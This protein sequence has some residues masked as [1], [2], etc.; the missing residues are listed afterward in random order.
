MH[1]SRLIGNLNP[2]SYEA[3]ESKY[4]CKCFV[5]FLFFNFRKAHDSICRILSLLTP[6]DS[7]ISCKVFILLSSIPNLHLITCLS[8]G[9]RLS[10]TFSRSFFMNC[11]S[12]ISSA[13]SAS[14]SAIIS[15]TKLTVSSENKTKSKCNNDHMLKME[16]KKN[17]KCH[18]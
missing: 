4:C 16:R 13:V 15:W 8:L 7:P 10:N 1:S 5:L 17:S 14:G 12:I 2:G 9:L 6:I 3:Y 18:I 11:L